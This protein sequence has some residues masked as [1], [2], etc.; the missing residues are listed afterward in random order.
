VR[1]LLALLWCEAF[2]GDYRPAV[3]VAVAYELAHACALVQDDILDG[4]DMR[5]GRP[6]IVAKY[7]L[8][9]AVLASDLLL[10]YVPKMVAKYGYLA[11]ER[12]AK[13]FDMVG[14]ACRGTTWGEFL[15]LQMT[16]KTEITEG[17]YDS[18]IRMKTAT[19][20]GAPSA[21]GAIVAGASDERVGAAW[22]FG[23]FLGMAYQVQDDLLDL[24][25]DEKTLGKPVFADL[26]GGKRSV[27]LIHCLRHCSEE[28]H[29]FIFGLLNRRGSYGELE[30]ARLQKV[31]EQCGSVRYA[32]E[33]A[34]G[35][36]KEAKEVLS[37]IHECKAKSQLLELSDYLAFRYW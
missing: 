35:Y 11:S 4:A 36:V 20:L 34:M 24:T 27:V 21:S 5:R 17:E 28:D 37:S 16:D 33:K 14:E 30:K 32:R 12:L 8:S 25:G 19:L 6:S 10:F 15:D 2:S 31:L 7:G 22:R 29:R 1:A 18:M 3:P 26:R 9:N 13:L 23:E